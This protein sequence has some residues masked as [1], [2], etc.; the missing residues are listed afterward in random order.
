MTDDVTVPLR[1]RLGVRRRRSSVPGLVASKV[2]AQY[3]GPSAN[4]EVQVEEK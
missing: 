4:I 1:L 2:D 3:I